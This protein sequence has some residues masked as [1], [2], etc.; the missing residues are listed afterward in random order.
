M[1]LLDIDD[2]DFFRKNTHGEVIRLR[3]ARV[4]RLTAENEREEKRRKE[5]ESKQKRLSRQKK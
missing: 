2:L 5:Q 3:N 1:K 4:K